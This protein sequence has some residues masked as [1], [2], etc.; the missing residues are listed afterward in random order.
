M[1]QYCVT[2]AMGKRLI[3]RA[4]AQHP[5]MLRALEGGTVVIVAGTT[6]GYVAEEVLRSLGQEEGFT[7]AG[8]RRGIVSAPGAS[9]PGHPFPGDVVIQD[10]VWKKGLTISDIEDDLKEGDLVLKGGN[11]LDPFGQA[12]VLMA[13]PQGGT[14]LAA[15]R[16]EFGRRVELIVPIGLEKRVAEDIN[17]LAARSVRSGVRGPR[18]Y[19][20]LADTFTEID[21]LALL[22]GAEAFLLAAGGVYGAEG[23]IWLGIDGSDEQIQAAGDL[24]RSLAGEPLCLA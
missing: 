14:I 15:V 10:G 8:F 24:I 7:R 6:N 23:A 19:P 11:A 1:E 4:M 18:L 22:T 20:I 16:A 21:A 5:S 3:G 13:H 9:V 17:V 2:P 12:G